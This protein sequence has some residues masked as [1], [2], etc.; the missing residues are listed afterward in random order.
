M[1]NE[2]IV[3]EPS[4]GLDLSATFLSRLSHGFPQ[5][6]CCNLRIPY[7]N[8][9]LAYCESTNMFSFPHT[10][11]ILA[12]FTHFIAPSSLESFMYIAACFHRFQILRLCIFI[13][14]KIFSQY[15]NTN[16]LVPRFS[17]PLSQRQW[18]SP[19]KA[20]RRQTPAV[21]VLAVSHMFTC[22]SCARA[23]KGSE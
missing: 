23:A 22:T 16:L 15:R 17:M 1:I 9:I 3:D 11:T 7:R 13:H 14:Q 21:V 4:P 10:I 2:G 8:A 6:T 19:A 18:L 12:H 5:S 20:A